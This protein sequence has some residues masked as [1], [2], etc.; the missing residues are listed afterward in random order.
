MAK[1][2]ISDLGLTPPNN[3]PITLLP[4]LMFIGGKMLAEQWVHVPVYISL[5]VV[6]LMLLTSVGASLLIPDKSKPA[7]A[8][9]GPDL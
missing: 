7:V 4:V 5:S 6:A 1:T 8:S 2:G 3:E 9:T